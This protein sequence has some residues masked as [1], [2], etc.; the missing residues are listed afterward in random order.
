[1]GTNYSIT[2]DN[3]NGD[4]NNFKIEIEK[5]L[6]SI[7]FSFSTYLENSEI[8]KINNSNAEL[9]KISPDFFKVLTKALDYS[10]LS[11]GTYDITIGPLVELWG[12]N[13]TSKQSIPLS[14]NI[15]ATLND[16][17]YENIEVSNNFLLKKNKNINI[18]LNSIAKGYAVDVISEFIESNDYDNY[19]VE[20]GGE[21]RSK[22]NNNYNDWIIGIQHPFNNTLITTV[23]LNN[24]SMATSGTYNN[25]FESN[26]IL[27]SHIINPKTGYPY[28]YKTVSATV[29]SKYCIDAD[30]YATLSM[31]MN[32]NDILSLVNKDSN[33]EV[34][35]L[36]LIN[37]KIIEYKS[38][39]FDDFILD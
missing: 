19:L 17:G 35:I 39:R 22:Q 33:T 27:Y 26:G 1:M 4:K 36:E 37:N 16:V 30:A 6:D 8:S 38:N 14:H 13:N 34:Y 9:I 32:P 20:I 21:L 29:I 25:Y 12:F 3:F 28:E 7:N 31:T 11:R 10:I 5:I 18:D 24:L 23:K 2:I 15:K